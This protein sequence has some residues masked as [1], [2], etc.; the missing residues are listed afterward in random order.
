MAVRAKKLRREKRNVQKTAAE[1]EWFPEDTDIGGEC[2][3][4]TD[5]SGHWKLVVRQAQLEVVPY[6]QDMDSIKDTVDRMRMVI[7]Q[8]YNHVN[9]KKT[10]AHLCT[11]EHDRRKEEKRVD[12]EKKKR[13]NMRR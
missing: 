13:R 2:A 5:K 1:L 3:E 9:K 11:E 4:I 8:R 10:L 7:H 12:L 6:G